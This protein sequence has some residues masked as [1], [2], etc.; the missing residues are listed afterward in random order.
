MSSQAHRAGAGPT[1]HWASSHDL[2]V[3][4][5]QHDD[6]RVAHRVETDMADLIPADWHD[7]QI[8]V[9]SYRAYRLREAELVAT[10]PLSY[11]T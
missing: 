9:T 11:L 5:D 10:K 7:Q 8:W 3:M 2:S 1:D 4:T 6:D